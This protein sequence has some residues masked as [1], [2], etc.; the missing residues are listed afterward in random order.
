[1]C[2]KG[3]KLYRTLVRSKLDYGCFVYGTAK[4]SNLKKLDSLHTTAI[5]LA[6]GAFRSSPAASI[7]DEAGEPTLEDRRQKLLAS[8]IINLSSKTQHPT[9]SHFFR[10]ATNLKYDTPVQKVAS[11]SFTYL[12]LQIPIIQPQTYHRTPS[13]LLRKFK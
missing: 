1:M 12:N 5:R 4:K 11:D 6:P 8:Y 3:L 2:L 10:S 9:Y 7:L 13:W